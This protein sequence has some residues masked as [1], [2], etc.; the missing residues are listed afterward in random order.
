[1]LK[2]VVREANLTQRAQ[3][4]LEE[5]IVNGSLRAG[6]RLPSERELVE[7]LGVSKTV[8]RE[9][10]RSL[11]TKGLIEVR[12]GSG[13]Y[14]LGVGAHL[15]SEPISLLMRKHR[16]TVEQIQ[17]VRAVLEVRIAALAAERRQQED[18]EAMA[19]TIRQVGEADLSPL[20]Y[21]QL[22][23]EFHQRL[24][25]ATG[26]PLFVVMIHSIND[27]MVEVRQRSFKLGKQAFVQ[28]SVGDHTR[29]LRCVEAGDV[30]GARQAMT[31]HL[32][33]GRAKLMQ[34]EKVRGKARS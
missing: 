1:M 25:A 21:A 26:N 31:D 20:R 8:V 14:V 2:S 12:P 18:I 29:I 24:A 4:Q 28:A 32:E 27:V 23:V 3:A 15:M 30:E 13:M 19:E 11:A 7:Q 33:H 10:M 34:A 22:D 16:L 6:E 5:L 9:A 17:E